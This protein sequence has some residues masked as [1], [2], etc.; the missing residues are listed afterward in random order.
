MN[1]VRLIGIT[2]HADEGRDNDIYPGHPLLY[3]E[4]DT[5]ELLRRVGLE[6]Y[7]IPIYRDGSL[8]SLNFLDAL[9]FTGGGFLSLRKANSRLACLQSTG[10]SRYEADKK[11]IE[12]G[13]ERGLPMIGI[14]RGAQMINEV[15]GGTLENIPDEGTEHHQER[16]KV[17]P[18]DPVHK[19]E[20]HD[21]SRFYSL[22]HQ[23]TLS[24]NSF[25][26]QHIN[27]LGR[28]LKI[29]ARSQP[30]QL[31]EVFEG[32]NHPFLFGFQFHP[33]KLWTKQPI[34]IKFFEE[35]AQ[36]ASRTGDY[37]MKN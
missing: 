15:L 1:Q 12:Y 32:T 7:L 24:V 5:I 26:R 4:R 23:K 34:W 33:E 22:L 6:P 2:V 31:I 25:H 27:Q 10:S 18:E 13:L 20:L 14:C 28:D 37:C 9:L 36:A 8:P 29:S 35:F 3:V 16:K 19:I 30:D 11:L 17:P 21:D